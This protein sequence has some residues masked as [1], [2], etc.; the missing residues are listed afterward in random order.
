MTGTTATRLA[1]RLGLDGNPLRRRPDHP[2]LYELAHQNSVPAVAHIGGSVSVL[3]DLP[4]H[5]V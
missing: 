2:D 5:S 3:P 4:R 1:R